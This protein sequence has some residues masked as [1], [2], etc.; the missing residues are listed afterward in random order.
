[1]KAKSLTETARLL[2]ETLS[3]EHAHGLFEA[4]ADP[5]VYEHIHEA[6]AESV[7][8]LASQFARLAN[9]PTSDSTGEQWLNLAIRRR[10]DGCLIG[11]LQATI[12]DRRAEVAYLIGPQYW[13][14]GYATEAMTAFQ[15]FIRQHLNIA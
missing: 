11:R 12:I 2:L 4:L 13:G 7:A 10:E 1:M 5:R 15:D 3:P 8:A 9:G 14:R 6:P